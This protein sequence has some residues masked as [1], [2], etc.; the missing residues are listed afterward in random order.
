[1]FLTKKPKSGNFMSFQTPYNSLLLFHGLGNGK[2]CASITVCEE[3][4]T[5]FNQLNIKY[6]I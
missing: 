4:R 1:M 5:Y 3:M 2:T 6:I